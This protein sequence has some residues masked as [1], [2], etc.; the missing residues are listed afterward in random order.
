MMHFSQ[1]S[2]D[3]SVAVCANLGQEQQSQ[4]GLHSSVINIGLRA[5]TK[6]DVVIQKKSP[7]VFHLQ[8]TLSFQDK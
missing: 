2:Q 1:R 8:K 6:N 7:A 5:P 4:C 3:G